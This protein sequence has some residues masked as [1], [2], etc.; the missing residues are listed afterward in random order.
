MIYFYERLNQICRDH[1]T[2]PTTVARKIG[3]SN[4]VTVRWKR[5]SIPNANTIQKLADYFCVSTDY[6]LCGNESEY[7]EKNDL[8]VEEIRAMRDEGI[9]PRAVVKIPVFGC[10][11]AGIPIEAITDI[12][13]YEEITQ[14]MASKGEHFALKIR[15]NSMEPRICNGDVI[16]LLRQDDADTGDIAAVMINGSDA[17]CKKIKKTPEGVE[18][19]PLNTE[20]KPMFFT[21][22]QVQDLPVRI[23][24]KVVELRAKFK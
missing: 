19:I 22:Q 23:I 17:T 3:L 8:I 5:G 4:S 11:A 15:G 14:E 6:L 9:K 18:L 21:N 12:E 13:D 1:G 20:Y 2:T 16:I 10:I 7:G 24:G